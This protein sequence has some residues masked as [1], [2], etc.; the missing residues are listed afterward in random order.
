MIFMS[1]DPRDKKLTEETT[2]EQVEDSMDPDGTPH[3]I[4]HE[5][6][7]DEYAKWF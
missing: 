3:H 7:I 4:L 2:P 5:E 1:K 6:L